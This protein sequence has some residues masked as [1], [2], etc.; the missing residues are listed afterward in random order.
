M[1]N[2]IF[3]QHA[4]ERLEERGISAKMVEEVIRDPDNADYGDKG[5]KIAQKLIDEKLLRVIYDDEEYRIVV[6]SAYVTSKVEKYSRWK[7]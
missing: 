5:R 2:I 4:L 3:I 6:I 7:I 1:K